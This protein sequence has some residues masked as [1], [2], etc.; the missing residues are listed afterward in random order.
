MAHPVLTNSYGFTQNLFL[1][2][3]L[4]YTPRV[5]LEIDAEQ[6]NPK[7]PMARMLELALAYGDRGFR[8]SQDFKYNDISEGYVST[9]ISTKSRLV[10]ASAAETKYLPWLAQFVGV[11]L[12]NTVGGTTP[13]SALPSNWDDL[14]TEIDPAPDVTYNIATIDSGGVVV[15]ATP[16]GISEGDTVSIAGTSNFNGQY[17]V[18]SVSGTSLTLE[19]SVSASLETTGTVTLVDTS[20]IELE[21]FDLD[22]SNVE[23]AQ[24]SLLTTARTGHNAGT[25]QAI[26]DVL[27]QVLLNTKW[28]SYSVQPTIAPWV[29]SIRTLTSE[30]PN[31]ETG[32]PSQ[33]V[34]DELMPVKPMGFT[35]THECVDLDLLYEEPLVEY[36]SGAP[37]DG[38]TA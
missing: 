21:S 8:Q 7:F 11:A 15:T 26:I 6:S 30:T 5:L 36:N 24:R 16:T 22:D 38:Y 25:K 17:L 31:G 3:T 34:L 13:W 29:I 12:Q 37:Y 20:W 27:N 19:P 32:S 4:P 23:D 10:D 2:E 18:T 28:F 9:D 33:V 35:I 14:H 1:R